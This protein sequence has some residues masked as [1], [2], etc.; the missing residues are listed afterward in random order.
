MW[1]MSSY[2]ERARQKTGPFSDGT[3]TPVD[4]D[5][6]KATI[7]TS[8]QAPAGHTVEGHTNR[9]TCTPKKKLKLKKTK[10]KKRWMLSGYEDSSQYKA[11]PPHFL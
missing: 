8:M 10:T 9:A 1:S 5:I 11:D 4:D 2:S 3:L 7:I 6:S